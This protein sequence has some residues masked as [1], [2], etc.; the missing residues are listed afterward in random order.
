MKFEIY[1][2]KDGYRWRLVAKNGEI[3]ADSGEAYTRRPDARRAAK[4]V[5]GAVSGARLVEID[6]VVEVVK[7]NRSFIGQ[8]K[9]D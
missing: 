6:G 3:I 8:P 2:A 4:L 5:K 9:A 1:P 7:S